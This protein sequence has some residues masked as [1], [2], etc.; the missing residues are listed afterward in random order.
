VEQEPESGVQKD[1][2]RVER[3][4]R[5]AEGAPDR[6]LYGRCEG[7]VDMAAERLALGDRIQPQVREAAPGTQ[8]GVLLDMV[9]VVEGEAV[10][11]RGRMEGRGQDQGE[12]RPHRTRAGRG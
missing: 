1:A 9:V 11:E 12:Q 10:P 3:D 2:G 5:E 4:R 8:P 7:A 6:A